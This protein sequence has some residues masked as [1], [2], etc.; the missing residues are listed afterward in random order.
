MN[1][2]MTL[3]QYFEFLRQY[4]L[5]FEPPTPPIAKDQGLFLL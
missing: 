5:L 1:S 3:D 4:W 2:P